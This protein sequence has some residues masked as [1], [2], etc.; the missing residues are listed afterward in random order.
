MEIPSAAGVISAIDSAKTATY[1]PPLFFGRISEAD[2]RDPDLPEIPYMW[3][4]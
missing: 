3:S 4:T 2:A 1:G